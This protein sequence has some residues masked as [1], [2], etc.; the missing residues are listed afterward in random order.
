MFTPPTNRHIALHTCARNHKPNPACISIMYRVDSFVMRAANIENGRLM[1]NKKTDAANNDRISKKEKSHGS[2]RRISSWGEQSVVESSINTSVDCIMPS[3]STFVQHQ[4]QWKHYPLKV[5]AHVLFCPLKFLAFWPFPKIAIFEEIY[6][7]ECWNSISE[8]LDF[9][10]FWKSMPPD[11]PR[12]SCLRHSKSWC[13]PSTSSR[14]A[15]TP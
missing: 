10:I 4:F 13:Q 6:P 5:K 3:T 2:V 15:S 8:P 12:G 7:R 1:P 11:P 14:K 9:K